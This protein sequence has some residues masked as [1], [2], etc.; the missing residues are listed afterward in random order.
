MKVGKTATVDVT[1][2]FRKKKEEKELGR[3]G[4]RLTVMADLSPIDFPPASC[5][6][7]VNIKAVGEII[8]LHAHRFAYFNQRRR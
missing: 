4:K 7:V 1:A 6:G 3:R 8:N 5:P 2:H